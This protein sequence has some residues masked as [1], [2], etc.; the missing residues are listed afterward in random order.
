MKDIS[1]IIVSWNTK[2]YL[3]KCLDAVDRHSGNLD[4]EII[5]VDNGSS[6]QSSQAVMEQ[7]PDVKIIQNDVNTG[8]VKANN[9][10]FA[11]STGKYI[12]LLNTDAFIN[13]STLPNFYEHM[14]NYPDTGAAGCK[15]LYEDQTLQ[16][17]CYSFPTILTELWQFLF[18]DRIFKNSRIF[19]KYK[20]TYWDFNDMREVDSVMGACMILRRKAVDRVGLFDEKIFMYSEEV[21][22]C[23]RLK[24]DDWKVRFVPT[25]SAIH[26]WGGS[27]VQ[28]PLQSFLNLY[29]SRVYFFRK[30]YGNFHASIYKIILSL[31]AFFRV[32]GYLLS[33]LVKSERLRNTSVNYWKLLLS[34][35]GY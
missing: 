34:V 14:E 18:L 1:I 33:I 12:L 22:L 31:G 3:L 28:T 17:S 8:F 4:L 5:V 24:K 13:S 16:R 15:L 23:Y 7:Y 32:P 25:A 20:M 2:D 21:D 27:S 11:L 26:I 9:Q 10:G 35:F 30:H 6:D 19:G 29:K